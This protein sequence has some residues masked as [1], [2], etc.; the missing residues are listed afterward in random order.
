MNGFLLVH[1]PI[2]WTSH[3][4]VAKSRRLLGTRE[5]GHLGTLDPFADGLLVLAIGAA[6]KCLPFMMEWSKVYHATLKLGSQTDTGDLTGTVIASHEVPPLNEELISKVTL[7]F[8]GDQSQLPPMYSA[9]KIDGQKLVDLARQG[10]SIERSPQAITIHHLVIERVDDST[11]KMIADVSTGTYIRTLG[12]DIA[13]ELGT[14]GHLVQLQR[15][16]SGPLLLNDAY[17]LEE[18][19]PMT[20]LIAIERAL[21]HIPSITIHDAKLLAKISNG[22]SVKLPANDELVLLM[23]D[24]HLYAIYER[25]ADGY[26]H[27]RRGLGAIPR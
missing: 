19:S 10:K 24:A 21:S 16:S 9:K 18:L 17:S 7:K 14:V 1:K 5:I 27:S 23:S 13:K 6:T 2:G 26:Y 11:L 12:E 25:H 8:T 22:M 3:D 4:V 20:P 15:V